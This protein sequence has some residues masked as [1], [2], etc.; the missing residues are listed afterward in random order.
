MDYKTYGAYYIFFICQ[1]KENL[2]KFKIMLQTSH[3]EKN[4]L[5]F[6]LK[7]SAI[8]VVTKLKT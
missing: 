8:K 6:I 7:L 3:T 2:V 5:K 1:I 4:Y